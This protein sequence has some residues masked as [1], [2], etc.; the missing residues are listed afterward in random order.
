MLHKK[1]KSALMNIY[2]KK[3]IYDNRTVIDKSPT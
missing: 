1:Y 2:V 3:G